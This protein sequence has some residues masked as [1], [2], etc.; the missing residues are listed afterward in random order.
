MY[1]FIKLCGMKEIYRDSFKLRLR[2]Y[3]NIDDYHPL[4]QCIT[5]IKAADGAQLLKL[6]SGGQKC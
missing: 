5:A 4:R 3:P 1:L 2:G 6:V